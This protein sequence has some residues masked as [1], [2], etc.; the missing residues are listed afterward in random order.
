MIRKDIL[1]QL[2]TDLKDKLNSTNDY[3]SDPMNVIEGKVNYSEIYQFPTLSFYMF[4][5]IVTDEHLGDSREREM[6][7]II[8]GYAETHLNDFDNIHLLAQDVEE[9]LYNEDHWTYSDLTLLG[10]V[11][12]DI[13][14]YDNEKSV[15]FLLVKIEYTQD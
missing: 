9:F 12:F 4:R 14:N 11:E 13:I 10:D 2:K 15:F 1:T 3:N 8:Y 5:D 7:L 6:S